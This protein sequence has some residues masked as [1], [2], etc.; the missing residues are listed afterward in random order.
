MNLPVNLPVNLIEQLAAEALRNHPE[1]SVLRPAVEKELLYHDIL[2]LLNDGPEP[3]RDFIH[4]MT[5]FLAVATVEQTVA[6]EEFWPY[7][8]NT[9]TDQ[10]QQAR[11][12]LER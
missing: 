6:R 11:T 8:L 2:R 7:L 9:I 12:L 5:R 4:E 10:C 1:L 3:R